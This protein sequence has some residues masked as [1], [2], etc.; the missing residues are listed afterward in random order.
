MNQK[1][2]QTTPTHPF[3]MEDNLLRYD[4]KSV[5]TFIDLETFNLCLNFI[6]NRP[7]QVG[8]IQVKGDKIIDSQDIRVKWP[9]SPHLSI[10]REAAVITRFNPEEHEKL[11]ILPEEAFKIFWPMLVNSDYIIMHN[12]LRFDLYLLKGFAEM[13]GVDWKF[14]MNKVIDTKSVAQGIKMN[15]PYRKADGTFLEYQYRMA[16][17]VVKGIKTNLT[18]LGKEYGIEHDY[19]QLHHAI[20]DLLLN[21]KV[22]DKLKYQLD[23]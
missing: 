11:A 20:N 9:D 10:G 18:A 21:L 3:N 5:F 16:N 22:W 6:F 23:L 15:I 1:Q 2:T 12:G 17:A 7:W 8:I 4:K 14:I 19:E 13:M